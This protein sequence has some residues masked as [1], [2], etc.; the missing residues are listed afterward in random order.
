MKTRKIWMVL[1]LISIPGLLL[2][3]YLVGNRE[4]IYYS[5]IDGAIIYQKSLTF[6]NLEYPPRFEWIVKTQRSEND[7][8]RFMNENGITADSQ[9]G[10]VKA[11]EI[12]TSLLTNE[13]VI[14]VLSVGFSK[15]PVAVEYLTGHHLLEYLRESNKKDAGFLP[16]L[17]TALRE[18][19]SAI[20]KDFQKDFPD[21]YY[22]WLG[23]MAKK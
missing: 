1:A 7:L 9:S 8:S 3:L 21:A 14:C 2:F 18:P 19:D 23:A 16:R 17:S 13:Q 20:A 12:T 4:A 22:Q 15:Y 6:P 5:K 11:S 10:R